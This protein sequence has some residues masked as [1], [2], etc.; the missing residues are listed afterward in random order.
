[1]NM[2]SIREN[3][4][5]FLWVCLIGFVLS[6]VGV[7]GSSS[8]GGGF[9]G[10]ASLTSLFSD[11]VNPAAFVGKVADRKISRNE[12]YTELNLQRQNQQT[13]FNA[14]DSY[15]IGR[16]W[17]SIINNTIIDNKIVDLN[18]RTNPNELKSFLRNNPPE[19]LKNHLI[20][21]NLFILDS[22]STAFDIL[23]YQ[24]ALDNNVQ[25]VPEGL[26]GGLNNYQASLMNRSLPR[27]KLNYIYSLLVSV[28]DKKIKS[29]SIKTNTDVNIDVL[30]IDYAML[31]DSECTIDDLEIN[32][33]YTKNLKDKYTN[34]E[35]ILV[36]YVLFKNITNE[37]D[38]LEIVLNEEL[39]IK[40]QNFEQDSDPE[41]MG[42]DEAVLD[43]EL[44]ISDSISITQDFTG[45][46]GIPLSLGYNRSI[47]RFAFDQNNGDVT[48]VLTKEGYAYFRIIEKQELTTKAL[49]EVREEISKVLLLEK[50]KE[51]AILK[52]N[53]SM[54][55]RDSWED[56]AKENEF[57]TID[58]NQEDKMNANFKSI[59]K[60]SKLSGC[61]SVMKED[62]ITTI[63]DS[64]N[65]LFLV[66][67]NSLKEFSIDNL[68]D[69]YKT[70]RD[71]IINTRS[72]SIFS[73]WLQYMSKN[74]DI[75]DVRMKSI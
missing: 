12:F 22:D 71:R 64:N 7:M 36:D 43:Y 60:N 18:L 62:D 15:Y 5:V 66:H 39:K 56:L 70:I 59:G 75:L 21:N 47:V 53:E 1:M 41:L 14:T 63:I 44:D 61:L 50:K 34:N 58:N 57:I 45:N 54:N 25:W 35:S 67:L 46:S 10:G 29:E 8:G 24:N 6:L 69:E 48:G 74:I 23:S 30:T 2:T 33:Y 40:R 38:S 28:S 49:S 31:E 32:E 13:V 68:N 19:A 72:N 17:E 52:I 16:A 27:A 11:N 73:N 3:S 9:L 26:K 20:T 65:K 51:M 4:K 37:N 55:K 42:F